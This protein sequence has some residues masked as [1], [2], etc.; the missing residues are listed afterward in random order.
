MTFSATWKS[1]IGMVDGL[2]ATEMQ[3][4]EF[5]TKIEAE[6]SSKMSSKKA[7]I[8]TFGCPLPLLRLNI[9]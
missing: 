7:E 9:I 8:A 2:P 4:Y 6:I 5:L 3:K 1:K